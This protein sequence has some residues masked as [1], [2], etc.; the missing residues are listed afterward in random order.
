MVDYFIDFLDSVLVDNL[1]SDDF[2]SYDFW[3][4]DLNLD[5]FLDCLWNF[6]NLLNDLDYWNW[7]LNLYFNNLRNWLNMIHNLSSISVLHWLHNSLYNLLNFNDLRHLNDLFNNLLDNVWNFD[8][9]L[10][11]SFYLNDLFLNDLNLS[12]FWNGVVNNLFNNHRLFNLYNLLNVNWNLNDF[13]NLNNSFHNLLH[14]SW[15]FNDSFNN[16]LN[17]N[18]LFS[19]FVNVLNYLHWNMHN[20]LY[21]LNLDDF[22]DLFNNFFNWNDLRNFNHSLYNLLYNFLNFNDFRNNSEDFKNII[23]IDDS[24]DFLV[25]HSYDSLIHL[26]NNSGSNSDFLKLFKKSLDED[27]QME[28]NSLG[29]FTRVGVN[30][31]YFN[32]F[33]N[34]LDNWDNSFQFVDF[35]DIDDFLLEEF[36][37][38]CITLFSEFWILFKVLFHLN[39]QHVDQV[40]CS[41]ILNW[42]F[43]DLLSEISEVQNSF[44]HWNLKTFLSQ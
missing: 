31:F 4:F 5:N 41:W 35:H 14:Y 32:D 13:W 12:N 6:N 37:E 20:F 42:D 29:L 43:N 8:N 38:S 7:L 25:D 23:D 28:L 36:E 34:V 44:N 19:E 3:N 27:S 11:N 21:F 26:E 10:H 33:W 9:L 17:F 16:L 1:L 30:V 24:H 18:D 22:D 15:N 39:C 2:Y 40:L